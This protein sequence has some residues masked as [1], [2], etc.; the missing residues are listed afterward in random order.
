M[1]VR[2]PAPGR[3]DHDLYDHRSAARSG[4]RLWPAGHRAAAFV[5]LR[6][7]SVELD[8][9]TDTIRDPRLRGDF[10]NY[11]PDY[12]GHS[13]IEYGNRIG[14]FR[15]LDH[16]QS[17]GWKVA[18]AVNGLVAQEKPELVRELIRRDVAILA[19]G[20]SASR[21]V[22]SAMPEADERVLLQR[23]VD[24]ITI[25]TGVRPRGYASQDYGYSPRTPALL[26]ESGFA[27]AVD[28]PNDDRP[29]DFG[30]ERRLVMIP[31]AAE[32][33]DAHAMIARKLRPELWSLMLDR[34]LAF[35]RDEATPGAVFVLSL[36]PWVA[37]AA[38]RFARLQRALA[39]HPATD[40]WQVH[41]AE[42]AAAWQSSG[43]IR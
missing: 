12:R 21:L 39:N 4:T 26:V 34:A 24:A 14:V 29:F 19:G 10:G 30:P 8:P 9:P 16:L 38:H 41:P 11:F 6:V 42:I 31:V 27:Y 18:A 32:L 43:P 25:A 13:L 37:G 3:L 40:F 20:W 22:S 7:E 28:W 36:H 35:W 33:D 1:K 15:L 5:L 2:A 23:T 17:L